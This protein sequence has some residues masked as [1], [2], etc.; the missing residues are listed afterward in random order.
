MCRYQAVASPRPPGDGGKRKEGSTK[1]AEISHL[2]FVI[3]IQT[4]AGVRGGVLKIYRA[5]RNHWQ[6]VAVDE[7]LKESF[8]GAPCAQ[9]KQGEN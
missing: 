7:K 1:A 6:E 9:N 4:G 3:I 5:H 8:A 2:P